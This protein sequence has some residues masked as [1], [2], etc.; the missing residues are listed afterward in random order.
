V[1]ALPSSFIAALG[2]KPVEAAWTPELHEVDA[3]KNNL[4][5]DI[6]SSGTT[7]ATQQALGALCN[8]IFAS[9]EGREALAKYNAGDWAGAKVILD[10]EVKARAEARAKADADAVDL[11]S[12]ASMALDARTKDEETTANV[13]VDY[14]AVV[15]PDPGVRTDWMQLDRLYQDA[16]RTADARQAAETA[17]KLAGDG[18]HA[19]RATRPRLHD[20]S[21][22]RCGA[23]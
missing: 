20:A 8:K 22:C 7:G 23:R 6:R 15:N 18:A 19:L 14:Q 10:A 21:T 12:V 3:R 4:L 17:V 9:P 16:G 1:P 5:C 11:R 2:P 13:I